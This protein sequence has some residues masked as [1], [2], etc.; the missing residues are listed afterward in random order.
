MSITG[1]ISLREWAELRGI[2]YPTA[3]RW[4]HAGRLPCRA[5]Q[6]T[7]GRREIVVY[8]DQPAENCTCVDVVHV[9]CLVDKL[10]HAGYV[11]LSRKDATRLGVPLPPC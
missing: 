6:A 4:F 3:N 8:P 11:V 1:G 5:E 9:K 2:S 10:A 7:T